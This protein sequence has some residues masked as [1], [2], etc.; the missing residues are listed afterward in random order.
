MLSCR[1]VDNAAEEVTVKMVKMRAGAAEVDILG[2]E[3]VAPALT[4]LAEVEAVV[5]CCHRS[6]F[7]STIDPSSVF[8]VTTQP[9]A[10]LLTFKLPQCRLPVYC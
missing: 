4:V 8:S 7:K 6:F 3:V 9:I 2:E 10:L 1:P 5:L